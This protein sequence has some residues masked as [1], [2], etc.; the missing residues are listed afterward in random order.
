MRIA[1]PRTTWP[2]TRPFAWPFARPFARPL[3]LAAAL[4]LL[5]APL[6]AALHAQ[7]SQT[8]E[9]SGAMGDGRTVHL[10]NVNGAVRVETGDGNT[11]EVR[12]TKHWRRGNPERVR[13]EA[14][15]AGS[16]NGDVIIC[17]LSTPRATCD[18]DGVHGNR[19]RQGD[20]D[21]DVRVEFLVRVPASAAVRANTVNGAISIRGVRG[22]VHAKTVNGDIDA[23]STTGGVWANTVN[24]SITVAG[25]VNASGV[26]YGTVNGSITIELPADA[27]ARVDLS[28]VNGRIATEFPLTL[29]G[30][31]DPRRLRADIGQGGG[32]VRARTVNGGIRLR[33]L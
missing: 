22:D 16:G 3:A 12:A 1:T 21:N 31:L 30:I 9:W 11:V 2:L 20:R 13:I 4:I 8:W 7:E 15:T 26:E 28:T 10:H 5:T 6:A 27:N 29:D 32:V 17:A 25:M 33:K 24:G 19:T 23:R 14:R 18:A